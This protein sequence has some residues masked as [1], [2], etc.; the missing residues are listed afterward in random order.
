MWCLASIQQFWADTEEVARR[1]TRSEAEWFYLS[2]ARAAR[3][4]A[5]RSPEIRSR[6][7]PPHREETLT[8]PDS[9]FSTR[10]RFSRVLDAVGRPASNIAARSTQS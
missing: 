1:R 8:A 6:C 4:S 9:I 2:E 7:L 5:E 10:K 3:Y